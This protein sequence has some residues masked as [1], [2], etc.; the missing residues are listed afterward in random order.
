MQ[1]SGKQTTAFL[2][3]ISRNY[4][5]NLLL[6]DRSDILIVEADEYDRSFLQIHA[7][8]A[9]ITSVGADHLDVYKDE[10]NIQLAFKQFAS[11]L[12][13]KGVLIVED[14]IPIDFSP[15]ELG[16]VIRYS[17]SNCTDFYAQN[18]RILDGK[19][20]FDMIFHDFS[21]TAIFMFCFMMFHDFSE[22]NNFLMRIIR[23]P[24][25]LDVS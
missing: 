7:D 23:F 18:V 21:E 17:A 8:V 10:S 4:N 9:I 13:K 16:K 6:S 20:I 1:K 3:G 2:G 15:P 11:Q 19:M 14:S 12:K 25:F 5:T 24:C 22:S